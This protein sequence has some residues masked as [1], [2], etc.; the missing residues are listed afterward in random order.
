MDFDMQERHMPASRC[1][2]FQRKT[3]GGASLKL[4]HGCS[5]RF[6]FQLDI[7]AMKMDDGR[8]VRRHVQFDLVAAL[9]AERTRSAF[10]STI[11]NGKVERTICPSFGQHGRE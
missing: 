6:D 1:V 9:N 4:Q 2:Q 8:V 11:D 3:S 7:V 10:Q 5:T